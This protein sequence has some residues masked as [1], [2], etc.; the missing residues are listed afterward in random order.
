MFLI[1]VF[2]LLLTITAVF[3]YLNYRFIRLP[4]AIGVMAISLAGSVGLIGLKRLGFPVDAAARSLIGKIDFDATFLQG[5]LSF[6]LFAGSLHVNFNDLYEERWSI[7][8]LSTV[9]VFISTFV[10]GTAAYYGLS[11]AGITL[12]Y[13]WCLLFGA[14]ISPT[15]PIA[16]LGILR[17]AGIPKNLETQIVGESL[18]NDGIG[19]VVFLVIFEVAT[20]QAQPS[21]SHLG[22]IFMR[23]ALGGAMIGLALGWVTYLALKSVDNYQVEI[24]LTL[25]LVMGGYAVANATGASGPIAMVCAG[26][27]IGNHGRR[28]AMSEQTRHHLDAFWEL[29]DEILNA[30]LFVMIGFQVL[31]LS[32]SRQ[33]LFAGILAIPVLLFSRWIS[34]VL[35]AIALARWHKISKGALSIMTWGGLRGGLSV[36]LA[37]SLPIGPQR[38]SIVVITY[39]LVVFS[40]LGQGLSIRRVVVKTLAR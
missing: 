33:L 17:S 40:I 8:V 15:D 30:L 12:N 24:L 4:T 18:F 10:F 39:V 16:V 26:L 31:T 37:L 13:P 36:A 1:D 14:L 19:I 9:G 34:V 21:P 3:S 2:A 35:P 5:M 7:T 23:E 32:F 6:L 38:D 22:L 20:G 27:L 11:A 29:A 25:A 28:F